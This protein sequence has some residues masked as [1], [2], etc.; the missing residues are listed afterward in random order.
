MT[1]LVENREVIMDKKK[2]RQL[3]AKGWKVGS[4][5]EFLNLSPE[6]SEYIDL[7]ISLGNNVKIK[8]MS[9]KISQVELAKR[10]K[11]SQS[12]IAKMEIGDPSVS[13]DLQVKTL[14][15]LGVTRKDLAKIISSKKALSV[16]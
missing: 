6:E 14:L 16:A 12:R 11:S 15:F 9:K 3:E 2:K 7:K 4:V 13:I 10:I 1:L 8:R 5:N